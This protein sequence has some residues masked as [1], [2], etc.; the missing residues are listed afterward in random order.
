[1]GNTHRAGEGQLHKMLGNGGL[2]TLHPLLLNHLCWDFSISQW[3]DSFHG[4]LEAVILLSHA[5]YPSH[6]PAPR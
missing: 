4:V 5:N 2:R 3:L 6:G 1:M